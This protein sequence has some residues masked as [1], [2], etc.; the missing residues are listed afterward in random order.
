M[1]FEIHVLI[2]LPECCFCNYNIKYC[3]PWYSWNTAKVGIKH[4]SINHLIFLH[5]FIKVSSKT[6]WMNFFLPQPQP[7]Y[8]VSIT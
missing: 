3:M 8:L 4:Q 5:K 2:N 1:C 7:I 6:W